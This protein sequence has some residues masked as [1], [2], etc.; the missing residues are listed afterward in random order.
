MRS[1]LVVLLGLALAGGCDKPAPPPGPAP[2]PSAASV[3]SAAAAPSAGPS[4]AS[5]ASATASAEVVP[6]AAPEPALEAGSPV[7]GNWLKCY[8]HF[9]PRTTP[10]VDVMRLGMMCGPSNGMRKVTGVP[11]TAV[12]QDSPA[13][14][15][16]FRASA[17]DCYRI[18]A[19]GSPSIEDLD[20]EVLDEKGRRVAFDTSDDRWP[21]VKADGAFCVLDDGDYRA[22]VRAQRGSGSY[23]IEIWRLR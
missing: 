3:A 6:E 10:A 7:G 22:V 23:A 2:A 8:A 1:A 21:I 20:V 18:F 4:A 15:H 14:E 17:G 5:D 11:E 16:R 13:R 9:Q 12:S 19:V